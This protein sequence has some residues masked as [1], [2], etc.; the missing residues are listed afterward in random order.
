MGPRE[1]RGVITLLGILWLSG[2]LWWVLDQWFRV[3]GAFG[4]MPHPWAASL[5]LCHGVAAVAG[6]YMLGWV[7]AR[8]VQ[9]W[10]PLRARRLSGVTLG[11]VLFSMSVSGFALMFLSD[12]GWQLV[13]ARTHDVLGLLSTLSGLQHGLAPKRRDMRSAAS[14]PW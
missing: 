9:V 12:D 6:M 14:L 10:W 4:S 7:S 13:A 2:V 1:R 11:V 8:H 5:L 3:P